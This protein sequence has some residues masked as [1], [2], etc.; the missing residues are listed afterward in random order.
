VQCSIDKALIKYRELFK[1]Y[2]HPPVNPAGTH[3]YA[4]GI[5]RRNMDFEDKPRNLVETTT[6]RADVNA[7]DGIKVRSKKILGKEKYPE[8]PGG[9][10]QVHE[11]QNKVYKPETIGA[12]S[13]EPEPPT[14]LGVGEDEGK[15]TKLRI[16]SYPTLL[17]GSVLVDPVGGAHIKSFTVIKPTP[18]PMPVPME[19]TPIINPKPTSEL[20]FGTITGDDAHA[21]NKRRSSQSTDSADESLPARPESAAENDSNPDLD[22]ANNQRVSIQDIIIHKPAPTIWRRYK[23]QPTNPKPITPPSSAGAHG[24]ASAVYD[25]GDKPKQDSKKREAHLFST[26]GRRDDTDQRTTIRRGYTLPTTK[27]KPAM[28]PAGATAHEYASKLYDGGDK[29]ESKKRETN[30]LLPH[31]RRDDDTNQPTTNN[32]SIEATAAAAAKQAAALGYT[33][34]WFTPALTHAAA[35]D[36]HRREPQPKKKN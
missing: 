36:I 30:S 33:A 29:Q 25:E 17:E 7:E 22:D 16:V 3:E 1:E 34:P 14:A 26:H 28:P 32:T 9:R 6:R 31:S 21:T 20:A 35:S 27:P 11:S 2:C 24:Y 4:Q 8:F 15:Y 19:N 18:V 12:R 13:A 23:L 5:W 10:P